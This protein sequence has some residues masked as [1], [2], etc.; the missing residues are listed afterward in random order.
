MMLMESRSSWWFE[1]ILTRI[2]EQQKLLLLHLAKVL[3]LKNPI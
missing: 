1:T 3:V 2:A